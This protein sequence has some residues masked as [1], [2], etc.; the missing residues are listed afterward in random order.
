MIPSPLLT[1]ATDS[2][3]EST[4]GT[5][6][7]DW[8]LDLQHRLDVAVEVVDSDLV[9]VLAASPTST[10]TTLRQA[11]STDQSLRHVINTAISSRTSQRAV[12][13]NL[14]AICFALPTAGALVVA[15]DATSASSPDRQLC[16]LD[17]IGSWLREPMDTELTKRA[18]DINVEPYRIASLRRI[19]GEA[20]ARGTGGSVRTVLGAFVEALNVWDEVEGFGYVATVNGTFIR[21]ASPRGITGQAIPREV[22]APAL[23]ALE[24]R[25]DLFIRRTS[26]EGAFEWLLVF[27]GS[28]DERERVRLTLYTDLLRDTLHRTIRATEDR[29]VESID[30][31]PPIQAG[32]IDSSAQ[33]LAAVLMSSLDTR[34]AAL[35]MTVTTGRQVFSVGATEILNAME[36]GPRPDRLVITSFDTDSLLVFAAMR[37]LPPFTMFERQV[38]GQGVAAAQR[39]FAK[40]LHSSKAGER[41]ERSRSV[42]TLFEQLAREAV[43]SGQD[44]SMVVIS[45]SP[46]AAQPGMLRAN[47]IKVRSCI[48]SGDFAGILSATEI[49]VLAADVSASQAESFSSRLRHV[50][51]SEDSDV[52][53]APPH[54]GVSTWSPDTDTSTSLVTSARAAVR[55]TV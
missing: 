11:L 5:S 43:H 34:Q 50:L 1:M 16:D 15:R 41:R 46:E 44:V 25:S 19:L 28:V 4:A 18:D 20:A 8:L 47:V 31:Q 24:A 35:T 26:D 54:F 49:V 45:F 42:D 38:A 32:A 55:P 12:V 3:S 37:D 13:D 33:A 14:Q 2:L 23:A 9:P 21:Y 36:G 39:W 29:L 48:R 40:Q 51:T 52:S 30:R 17:A 22:D 10:A 27:Q 7:P 6:R 53:G